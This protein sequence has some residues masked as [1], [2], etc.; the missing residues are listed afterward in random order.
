MSEFNQP[1]IPT[2]SISEPTRSIKKPRMDESEFPDATSITK[3]SAPGYGVNKPPF[4]IFGKMVLYTED[5]AVSLLYVA[6]DGTTFQFL[7]IYDGH[8]G[9]SCSKAVSCFMQMELPAVANIIYHQGVTATGSATPLNESE[10][11]AELFRRTVQHVAEN[12]QSI[13]DYCGTTAC[14][15]I[16]NLKTLVATIANLGD[17]ACMIVGPGGELKFRTT[18]HDASN[19]QEQ[20]RIRKTHPWAQFYP[21]SAKDNAIR[22]NG[23]LM[24]VRGFGDFAYAEVGID[25][26]ITTHQ[27]ESGDVLV[28]ASD[29]LWE[30]NLPTGMIGAGRPDFSIVQ[31]IGEYQAA[32]ALVG[33]AGTPGL[34]NHLIDRHLTDLAVGF[35]ATPKYARH[36]IEQ[37]RTAFDPCRDNQ[38]VLTYTVP[39]ISPSIDMVFEGQEPSAFEFVELEEQDITLR[40]SNSA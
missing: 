34:A 6:P 22:L 14:C 35:K 23:E 20:E 27:L 12:R 30:T 36:S 9:Y 31:D 8:G 16:I 33:T 4:N 26:D 38:T 19:L 17:S 32:N 5:R 37:L 28:I 25:P 18:D 29:G 7:G 24:V 40:R 39:S 2:R 3:G 1:D 11:L 13:G 21:I 10:V 15:A